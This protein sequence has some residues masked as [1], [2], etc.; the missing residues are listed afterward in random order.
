[1]KYNA[2]KWEKAKMNEE[3]RE[4]TSFPER[5]A[6]KKEKTKQNKKTKTKNRNTS[7]FPRLFDNS[8]LPK[9]NIVNAI[10]NTNTH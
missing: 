10:W 8:S 2:G 1:M 3:A 5:P 7:W 6:L 4:W 9:C